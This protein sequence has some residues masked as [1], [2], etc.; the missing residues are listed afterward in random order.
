VANPNLSKFD[1]IQIDPDMDCVF[2]GCI[3]VVLNPNPREGVFGYL[4]VPFLIE[5]PD[6]PTDWYSGPVYMHDVAF[7]VK[8]GR[9]RA[10][11]LVPHGRYQ[12]VG[13]L[14][15]APEDECDMA[16]YGIGFTADRLA[17]LA[18]AKQGDKVECRSCGRDHMLR[19][20]SKADVIN[21]SK[22]V[23]AYQCGNEMLTPEQGILVYSCDGDVKLGALK[24]MAG[25]YR[26]VAG[27][28]PS[29]SS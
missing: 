9:P 14:E 7:V 5:H 11:W 6:R 12:K 28:A 13:A 15:F 16:E 23:D 1:L 2:A 26:I 4:E 29:M 21:M 22:R 8:N 20:P 19:V 18:L 27:I 3:M 25:E 24:D 17:Q 10:Y